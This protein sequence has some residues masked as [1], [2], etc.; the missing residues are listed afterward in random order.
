MQKGTVILQDITESC[1]KIT[2]YTT[3]ILQDKRRL[4]SRDAVILQVL[5][6]LVINEAQRGFR[7]HIMSTH[8]GFA[9]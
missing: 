8:A 3:K 4:K 7:G 9:L 2:H 5:Q 6:L 1:S